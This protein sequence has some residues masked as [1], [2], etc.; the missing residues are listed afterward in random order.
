MEDFKSFISL[1]YLLNIL[2]SL[3]YVVTRLI[4]PVCTAMYELDEDGLCQ[5]DWRDT[6]ILMFLSFIVV[7]KNRRW[8]PLSNKEY[9]SN[10]F[11]FS[12]VANVILFFRQDVR[13]GVLYLIFCAVVFLVFP[14]P[15]YGGPDKV[16]FFRGQALDEELL[17][18]PNKT[19]LVE[20]YATWSPPCSRFSG[21]FAALSLKY[22]HDYFK[23]GKLDVTRYNK[24]AEKYN[25]DY[26][27]TSKN[28]PTL[29]LF[30]NGKEKTRRPTVDHKGRV[31]TYTFKEENIIRDFSLN[32]I[33]ATAKEKSKRNEKKKE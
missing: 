29:I 26:S 22:D 9:I 27:V 28:L 15:S 14:E 23:F 10:V 5:I 13:W 4:Q 33:Y 21:T 17:H 32:E 6:E 11:L 7:I 31:A 24:I 25:V 20:F 8:K 18:H 16:T 19:W 3:V 12:K 1:H 30:E 2:A